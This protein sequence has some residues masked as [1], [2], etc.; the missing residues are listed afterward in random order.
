MV[1]TI[2]ARPKLYIA[3]CG[4]IDSGK[5]TLIKT[6]TKLLSGLDVPI[7]SLCDEHEKGITIRQAAVHC[8]YKNVDI[9]FLDCPGHK[10]FKEEIKSGL[11]KAR[12]LF[13][14]IDM[15]RFKESMEY[16]KFI[17][18]VKSE[19]NCNILNEVVLYSKSELNEPLNYDINNELRFKSVIKGV[20]SPIINEIELNQQ[21]YFINPESTAIRIFK[22]ALSLKKCKNPTMMC[23]FGKDS[24]VML[25]LAKMAGV[26]DK[27]NVM[28]PVS[29]YDPDGI[30]P[31]FIKEVETFFNISI[32]PFR[33]IP[34]DWTFENHTVQ[35]MMLSKAKMLTDKLNELES[36][37][38]FIGIRRHEGDGTRSKEKF[39]STRDKFG[40]ANLY[41]TIY[42]PFGKE[43]LSLKGRRKIGS[44]RVAPL[45]DL[46]ELDIWL[47]TKAYNLP[48]C[49]EYFSKNGYRYRSLGDKPI[50]V[51]I[52]SN[53]STID[54]II[55]E[56][57]LSK[58][59]ERV[60]RAK[61]DNAVAYGMEKLRTKGFF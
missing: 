34:E 56:V 61:Q 46:T 16:I 4:L 12:V 53:A 20:L 2:S 27:I 44:I 47:I 51:P 39:F 33:V 35:E 57:K 9:I 23:S 38:C 59:S 60:C 8:P 42:E 55:E 6:A 3:V 37:V 13:K 40:S 7:D 17:N 43:A 21:N 1:K 5:S 52:K 19:V 26:L 48:I 22:Q 49:Q 10:E 15:T 29:G 32:T 58:V 45:L 14:L 41:E 18:E 36:T 25:Q 30:S 50:T 31:E 28:Y 54:D 11:S 24:L